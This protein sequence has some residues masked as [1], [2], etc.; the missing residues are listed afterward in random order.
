VRGVT[1]SA[2]TG[3][4]MIAPLVFL[5]VAGPRVL[6]GLDAG[7]H[8]HQPALAAAPAR[9]APGVAAQRGHNTPN[10]AVI[11]ALSRECRTTRLAA[12]QAQK[13]GTLSA[14]RAQ[15]YLST[16]GPTWARRLARARAAVDAAGKLVGKNAARWQARIMS[17]LAAEARMVYTDYQDG[18]TG[19]AAAAYVNFLD[20]LKEDIRQHC[21]T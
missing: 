4:V 17:R 16:D 5:A 6:S 3:A 2:M 13:L 19:L 10:V 12:R 1:K 8:T 14:V 21:G 20:A 11:R 18:T 9:T 15:E 7:T